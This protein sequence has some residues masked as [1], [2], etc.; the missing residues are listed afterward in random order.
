MDH[1]SYVEIL[2]AK[3]LV[4]IL[5]E[6]W[7]KLAVIPD[8]EINAIRR[9]VD[10]KLPVL[11]HPF[12]REG[13]RVRITRGPLAGIEGILARTK[14]DKGL[15][16]LSIELFQRSIAVEVDCALAVAA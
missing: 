11:A 3:G 4:R 8:T 13:Q 9:V 1:A 16:V 14:P 15:L 7:R 2:K 6:G 12:L 10:A 5:G